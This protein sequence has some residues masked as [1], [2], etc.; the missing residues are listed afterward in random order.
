MTAI[1]VWRAI[2]SRIP[3]ISI[4]GKRLPVLWPGFLD[5]FEQIVDQEIRDRAEE[6][7]MTI[8]EVVTLVFGD[9]GRAFRSVSRWR[10]CRGYSTTV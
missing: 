3:T 9:P 2:S 10:M 8:D 7:G 5:R 1:T 6:M 4:S